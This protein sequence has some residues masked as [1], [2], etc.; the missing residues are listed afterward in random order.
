MGQ[1]AIVLA[2]LIFES[3]IRA[4][5]EAVGVPVVILKHA[6]AA[7]ESAVGAKGMILDMNLAT[8]D[9]LSICRG[10]RSQHPTMP[11]VA[12]LSH[13]QKELAEQTRAAGA[14]LVLPRSTFVERLP[15]LLES[16][17]NGAV[18]E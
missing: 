6:A 3:R 1:I 16:L 12:F 2:D 18:P 14:S 13:V 4:V 5:A 9:A 17:A 7:F 15:K 8:D 11:I 10:L